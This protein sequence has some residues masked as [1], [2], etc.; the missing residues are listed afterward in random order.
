MK[1]FQLLFFPEVVLKNFLSAL[2]DL[3]GDSP[4]TSI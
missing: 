4:K 2:N 1:G 3:R